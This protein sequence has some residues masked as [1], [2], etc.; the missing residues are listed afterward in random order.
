MLDVIAPDVTTRAVVPDTTTDEGTD[1][2]PPEVWCVTR[3]I[4]PECLFKALSPLGPV[5]A[6]SR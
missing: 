4:D 2:P 6:P 3:F 1:G 5:L